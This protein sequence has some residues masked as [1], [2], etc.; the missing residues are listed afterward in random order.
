MLKSEVPCAGFLDTFSFDALPQVFPQR[1]TFLGGSLVRVAGSQLLL[2]SNP[3]CKTKYFVRSH[4]SCIMFLQLSK[5][6]SI[7]LYITLPNLKMIHAF[8][9]SLKIHVLHTSQNCFVEY[10]STFSQFYVL[11]KLI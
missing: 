8:H 6:G 7:A 1:F 10:K 5:L 9:T 11:F 3:V 2:S 4:F